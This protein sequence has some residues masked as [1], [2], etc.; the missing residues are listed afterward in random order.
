MV[1][2]LTNTR[3]IETN[4]KRNDLNRGL[5]VQRSTVERMPRLNEQL[6]QIRAYVY[7]PDSKI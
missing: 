7:C 5:K 2:I 6:M 4:A 3:K 1:N